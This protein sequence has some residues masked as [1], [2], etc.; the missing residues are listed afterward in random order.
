MRSFLHELVHLTLLAT[1][2]MGQCLWYSVI[3]AMIIKWGRYYQATNMSTW[4]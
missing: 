1:K 2:M 3:I 4:F